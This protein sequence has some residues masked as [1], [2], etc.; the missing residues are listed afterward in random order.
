M[1]GIESMGNK[2]QK[3]I[4]SL[5]N[6]FKQSSNT[7][8]QSI[9]NSLENISEEIRLKVE[10]LGNLTSDLILYKKLELD[11]NAETDIISICNLSYDKLLGKDY[12]SK[13]Y[14]GLYNTLKDI[15]RMILTCSYKIN[16]IPCIRITNLN[17]LNDMIFK[18]L[19]DLNKEGFSSKLQ[20]Y[21]I[22]KN[23]LEITEFGI[24]E[25]LNINID[26]IDSYTKDELELQDA[27]LI[28]ADCIVVC[29]DISR[30]FDNKIIRINKIPTIAN[31]LKTTHRE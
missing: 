27:I 16:K 22:N 6:T 4:A 30:T 26:F 19:Q 17:G 8:I 21:E 24:N 18:V 15:F 1:N 31:L 2:I 12:D 13:S 10:Q 9:A 23:Q 29:D 3:D 25:I 7:E 11:P 28:N 20:L 5:V 14:I